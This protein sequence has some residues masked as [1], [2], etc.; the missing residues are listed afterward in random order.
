MTA[1]APAAIAS[2]AFPPC[3]PT[4]GDKMSRDPM[5]ARNALTRS[6]R[7]AGATMPAAPARTATRAT[8]SAWGAVNSA[9]PGWLISVITKTS[10]RPAASTAA[11]TLSSPTNPC[12]M[13][14]DAP[15]FA[16]WS[17]MRR[18]V[19]GI[20]AV[21]RSARRYP[22]RARSR[23]IS[24]PPDRN[25]AHPTL[26]ASTSPRTAF[27]TDMA[28]SGSTT[29]RARI[30]RCSRR[31]AAPKRTTEKKVRSPSHP[32]DPLSNPRRIRR[33]PPMPEAQRIKTKVCLVGEAAVGKTSL[34]RRFVQDEFDDRYI[35]T[36]G[37]KVSK[38]EMTF[39]T[40]DRTKIHMDM[41]VWD[42]MGEKGFRDLLKEAFFHGA[43]GVVAACDLTR[44]S[45]LKELDDWVQSVFN[46]VGEI[47]VVYAVNKIDLKDEVMILY[48]DKEIAQAVR[49]FE[50][51]YFYASAKTGE[52][53]EVLFRRLGAMVLQREG[54]AVAT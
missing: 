42:I 46:V 11:R 45:T 8:S 10:A 24:R 34:I 43:K 12:V 44:Y 15:I 38:R 22:S 17:T 52:N 27:A 14:P 23:K 35:T 32:A 28:D 25:R 19:F 26:I 53:V 41:T 36:L 9:P 5:I 37:A 1:S 33:T 3:A 2:R 18:V 49:A 50:A 48:G 7:V 31:I 47:P 30:R 39:E 4:P 13:I 20:S 16:T 51:P 40:R 21:R 29:S 54:I 6:G